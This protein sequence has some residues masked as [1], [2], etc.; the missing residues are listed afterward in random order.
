MKALKQAE[1]IPGAERRPLWLESG[2]R[3]E[4]EEVRIER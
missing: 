4:S 3:G 2:T 1:H